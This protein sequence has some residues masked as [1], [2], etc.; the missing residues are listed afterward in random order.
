DVVEPEALADLVKHLRC[1]HRVTAMEK[2]VGLFSSTERLE[3]A[4]NSRNSSSAGPASSCSVQRHRQL[5]SARPGTFIRA[6]RPR[7]RT[8]GSGAIARAAMDDQAR[9]IS[10][11]AASRL[12]SSER[13]SA[14]QKLRRWSFGSSSYHSRVVGLS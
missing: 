12:L 1:L 6:S 13:L 9:R 7:L 14:L 10:A 3:A 4:V 5:P 2:L 11:G 8:S